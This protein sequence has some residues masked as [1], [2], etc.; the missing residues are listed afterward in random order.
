MHKHYTLDEIEKLPIW[1]AIDG[2]QSNIENRDI[3]QTRVSKGGKLDVRHAGTESLLRGKLLDL[4]S[5]Q[6]SWY[7]DY[8]I[9][10]WNNNFRPYPPEHERILRKLKGIIFQSSD[11]LNKEELGQVLVELEV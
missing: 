1:V 5:E 11:F 9:E 8:G 4:E 2:R 7:K 10:S 6:F 3:Y